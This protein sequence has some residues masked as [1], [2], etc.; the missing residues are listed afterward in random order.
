ML[1][2]HLQELR[3]IKIQ[4][5]LQLEE[6]LEQLEIPVV[7]LGE[8]F[9]VVLVDQQV[10]EIQDKTDKVVLLVQQVLQEIQAILG[11]VVMRG[12]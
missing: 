3:E 2:L 4:V 11:L 8:I 12:I 7:D 9:Q 6:V 10:Q 1:L 5:T